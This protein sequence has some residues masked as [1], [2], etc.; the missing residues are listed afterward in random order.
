M[1]MSGGTWRRFWRRDGR[2]HFELHWKC[3][4]AAFEPAILSPAVILSA[5][6]AHATPESKD[7]EGA[8]CDDADSGSSS[9]AA[10]ANITRYACRLALQVLGL[11]HREP[12]C[13]A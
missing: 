13:H 10:R 12:H 3:Y 4:A 11:H 6:G 9:H 5:V 1:R 2:N 8:D 7:P